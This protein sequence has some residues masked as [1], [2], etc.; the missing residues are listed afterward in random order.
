VQCALRQDYKGFYDKEIRLRQELFYPPFSHLVKLIFHDQDEAKARGAALSFRAAFAA[1]YKKNDDKNQLIGPAP[2]MIAE[3]RGVYRFCILLKTAELEQLS[4][5][6]RQQ[7]LHL[8][9]DVALDIDPL[10]T[11]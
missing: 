4:A 10:N 6:L 2:A 8:R 9:E 1:A 11:M 7:G 5:F 3:F